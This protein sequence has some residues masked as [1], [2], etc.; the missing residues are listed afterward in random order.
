MKFVLTADIHLSGYG[1]DQLDDELGLPER[2]VSILRTLEEMTD[3]C[4]K[5]DIS[6]FVIAGDLLHGKSIIYAVAQDLILDFFKRNKDINFIVIDGNHDLSGRGEKVVSALK[7]LENISNVSWIPF[8]KTS[9]V[10]DIL[11]VPYSSNLVSEVKNNSSKI[12]ISHFGLNEGILNSGISIIA[13][14]GLRDLIGKY[15]L[16]L[17]GH[18][19]K[20]QE[21]IQDSISLYYVGSPIQ[22]DWG[23]AGDEKRF[24]VVDTETLEVKSIPTQNYKKFIE[25]KL[26]EENRR[27]VIE[28]ANEYTAEGHHVKIIF[29]DPADLDDL[30]ENVQIVDRTQRDITNRGIT[31]SMSELD[32]LK[33]Y[34]EIKEIPENEYNDYLNV[35]TKIIEEF[36]GETI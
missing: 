31:Q 4:Y 29:D 23:E 20:P 28:K 36:G 24:L 35:V 10:G 12:L 3:Y 15:Q 30:P 5:H 33:R 11:F 8:Y 16:V 27:H 19:H 13:D 18:Y 9:R 21:I 2:L 17:L 22:L 7:P 26:T 34:L 1:Q 6:H 25:M 14:V 32:K